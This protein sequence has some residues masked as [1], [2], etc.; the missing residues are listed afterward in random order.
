MKFM[1]VA[2]KSIPR[3]FF[4]FLFF[5]QKRCDSKMEVCNCRRHGKKKESASFSP[6]S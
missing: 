5:T 1:K 2:K 6:N 4:L 3:K